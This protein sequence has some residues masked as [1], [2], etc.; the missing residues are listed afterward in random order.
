M[1]EEIKTDYCIVGAGIAGVVLASKLAASGKKVLILDQGPR[2]TEVDRFNMLQ[3]SKE[4]LNDFADYN[5]DVP[6]RRRPPV[7]RRRHAEAAHG[8]AAAC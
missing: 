5:D 1:S 3:R 6:A 4:I 2:F 7:A 8:G